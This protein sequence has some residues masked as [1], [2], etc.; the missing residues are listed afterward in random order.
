[1][2][3]FILLIFV[4][5]LLLFLVF[6]ITIIYL[7]TIFVCIVFLIG[8]LSFLLL[9]LLVCLFFLFAF[10]YLIRS[11]V[12]LCNC[13]L[14]LF[15]AI[16]FRS[17]SRSLFSKLHWISSTVIHISLY[18]C[19]VHRFT[20][21]ILI[22]M[23]FMHIYILFLLFQILFSPLSFLGSAQYGFKWTNRW[24]NPSILC[25]IVVVKK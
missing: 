20:P 14:M 4:D 22:E 16:F 5:Y 2:V 17:Y 13:M 11:T 9:L 7:W 10:V 15:V 6:V 18:L 24:K 3:Y 8:N 1:M 21:H 19:I 25:S 23:W 12:F